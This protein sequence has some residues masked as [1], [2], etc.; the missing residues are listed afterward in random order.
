MVL[1]IE[2]LIGCDIE[3]A[4]GE[5][6]AHLTGDECRK[7]L[8]M[9][10]E[11]QAHQRVSNVTGEARYSVRQAGYDHFDEVSDKYEKLAKQLA[12][13]VDRL[14]EEGSVLLTKKNPFPS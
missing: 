10:L 7:A 1:S 6:V 2:G 12:A 5:D 8:C 14:E 4:D 13:K 11:L 9:M 3:A